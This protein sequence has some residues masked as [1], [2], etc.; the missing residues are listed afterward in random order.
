MTFKL[1]IAATAATALLISG[2][3]AGEWADACVERLE[4]DGRDS[5]GCS[6]LEAEIEA[7]PSLEDEFTALAAIED[8]AE[9]F[10]AASGDAQAAMAKCTR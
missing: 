8:P 7:N 6:C 4:A 9:R 10:D 2:A 3:T 5:S 1:S